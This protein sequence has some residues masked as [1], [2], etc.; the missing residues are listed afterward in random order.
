MLIAVA[1]LKGGTGKSTV[2]VNLACA[3][4]D[5]K[6]VVLV[7]CDAQGTATH[8][9]SGGRLP[10][11]SDH[12][13]LEDPK[14]VGQWLRRILA[15]KA[16][17]VVLDA[18]PH[19]GTVTKAIIGISDLVIVPCSASTADLL[20]TVPAM[21]LI[22]A[23]RSARSD[24][25]PMCLLLPSRVDARTTAGREIEKALQKFGEPVG[26]VIHQRTAFVDAFTAG[27]W[28]G[29]YAPGSAAHADIRALAT[30]VKKVKL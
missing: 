23:A 11:Q 13:P 8:Y 18:P 9:V 16:D 14:D 29:G 3:L 15:I 30:S 6:R 24:G 22:K 7:D 27:L 25:G 19:V 1:N 12:L 21:E 28:V 26:P 17:Y 2:A 10:I 4:A 5:G 20:A